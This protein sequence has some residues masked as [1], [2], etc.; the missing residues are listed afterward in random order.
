[1]RVTFPVNVV[2]LLVPVQATAL[3]LSMDKSRAGV[4]S[5]SNW[6]ELWPAEVTH[7]GLEGGWSDSWPEAY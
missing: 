4:M 3:E 1:M 2:T 6:A 7:V 5:T